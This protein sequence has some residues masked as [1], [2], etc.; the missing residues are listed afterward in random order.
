MPFCCYI[1][2]ELL[3]Y[4]PSHSSWCALPV[5]VR[6]LWLNSGATVWC[7]VWLQAGAKVIFDL[8]SFEIVRRFNADIWDIISSGYVY[9]VFGNSDEW[10]A[11]S[12]GCQP[13]SSAPG[14]PA[15]DGTGINADLRR[16]H[17]TQT[18]VVQQC[19]LAVSTRG[20]QGC[21]ALERSGEP[22]ICPALVLDGVKDP[23]G[24]GDLF[25]AG[26]V[27]GLLAG[28]STR[29][30]CRIGCT[31]GAAATQVL[32][33]S[34]TVPVVNSSMVDLQQFRG[35]RIHSLMLMPHVCRWMVRR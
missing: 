8:A 27:H 1:S 33:S 29:D 34:R 2:L 5:T 22:C 35:L 24:A 14:G 17:H 16:L 6:M 30:C 19:H 12:A 21:I 15:E 26:F 7:T 13:H 9:A 10:E 25:A 28:V 11:L 32:F 31:C 20:S 4:L 23:T 18:C 3:S